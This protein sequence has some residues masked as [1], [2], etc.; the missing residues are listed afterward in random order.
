MKNLAPFVIVMLLICLGGSAAA[1]ALK[2]VPQ[3]TQAD[4]AVTVQNSPD[5]H[6]LIYPTLTVTPS[7]IPTPSPNWDSTSTQIAADKIS[8]QQTLTA[9]DLQGKQLDVERLRLEND[10]L[11]MTVT[12]DAATIQ[13]D[14]ATSSAAATYVP[15]TQTVYAKQVEVQDTQIAL[16]AA[17]LTAAKEEPTR[18]IQLADAQAD[19]QTAGMRAWVEL[20]AYAAFAV[21]C[22]LMGWGIV[23][24]LRHRENKPAAQ[25]APT[26]AQAEPAFGE[27]HVKITIEEAVDGS[28]EVRFGVVPCS[29][30]DL[31]IFAENVETLGLA[32][33][34][35]D[36]T[37]GKSL[38][39][40]RNKR[41][42]IL[43]M[44]S[45]LYDFKMAELHPKTN[46]MSLNRKGRAFF[47]N[48]LATGEL[49]HRWSFSPDFIPSE[50]ET[51]HTYEIHTYEKP[52]EAVGGAVGEVP[53]YHPIG[54]SA[55][56]GRGIDGIVDGG[57]LPLPN[58][59]DGNGDVDDDEG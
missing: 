36:G 16:H 11:N 38:L 24:A 7:T 47:A 27:D 50:G 33:N 53:S 13:A 30:D 22:V 44:R 48:Y 57:Y 37:R 46:E 56:G 29:A 40:A 28:P 43:H 4:G 39:T 3:P 26:A 58:S 17:D 35:W 5:A 54:M 14:N 41:N 32:T 31:K 10:R 9:A 52:S 20:A 15:V 12:M 2:D 34:A 8:S 6:Y 59:I 1:Y 18:I 45:F 19:A 51:D 21:L 55:D 49:P 23:Y 25:P 42:A